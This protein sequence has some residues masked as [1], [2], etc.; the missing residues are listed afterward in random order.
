LLQITQL[1]DIQT[2]FSSLDSVCIPC[3]VVKTTNENVYKTQNNV[4][5]NKVDKT[6]NL[7]VQS[8]KHA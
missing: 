5:S 8:V 3:N 1:G 7:H 6:L 2:E 4:I